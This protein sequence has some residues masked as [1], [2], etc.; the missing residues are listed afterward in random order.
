M[1]VSCFEGNKYVWKKKQVFP[2]IDIFLGFF[3]TRSSFVI[4]IYAAGGQSGLIHFITAQ[5]VKHYQIIHYLSYLSKKWLMTWNTWHHVVNHF[6]I[7]WSLYLLS[8]SMICCYAKLC[9][10]VLSVTLLCAWH[11][12]IFSIMINYSNMCQSCVCQNQI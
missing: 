3:F 12:T 7:I 1:Y 2:L 8:S 10:S 11:K 6:A 9:I 5:K 4:S